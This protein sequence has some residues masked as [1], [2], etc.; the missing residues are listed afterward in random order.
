VRATDLVAG[1]V[2]AAEVRVG[3]ISGPGV[4]DPVVCAPDTP[5]GASGL[6]SDADSAWPSRAKPITP[7]T[8]T[9]TAASPAIVDAR[10][11]GRF[12]TELRGRCRGR[13]V[14]L[15]PGSGREG[16]TADQSPAAAPNSMAPASDWTTV[17]S[18]R[19]LADATF[20]VVATGAGAVGTAAGELAAGNA[21]L[22][23]AVRT[24]PGPAGDEAASAGPMSADGEAA[25]ARPMSAGGDAAFA[26]RVS[27]GGETASAGSVSEWPVSTNPVRGF[28]GLVLTGAVPS[29]GGPVSAGAVPPCRLEGTE[30]EGRGLALVPPRRGGSGPGRP[31]SPNPKSIGCGLA[32]PSTRRPISSPSPVNRSRENTSGSPPARTARAASAA[33]SSSGWSAPRTASASGAPRRTCTRP[34]AGLPGSRSGASAA[35]AS[36]AR[37]VV[38]TPGADPAPSAEAAR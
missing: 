37:G 38:G 17:R 13:R 14:P 33:K 5:G 24:P 22:S 30:L 28:T 32:R 31:S 11:A 2:G 34:T 15:R 19:E 18:V 3:P 9:T 16:S 4:P 10:Y 35:K 6:A 8:S 29:L 1:G 25:S 20:E 21:V 27:A 23:A 7:R 26:R 12:T 36:S